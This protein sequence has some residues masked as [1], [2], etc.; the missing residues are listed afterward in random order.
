[1]QPSAEYSTY[2]IFLSRF[3]NMAWVYVLHNIFVQASAVKKVLLTVAEEAF[4]IEHFSL[5]VNIE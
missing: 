1:M 5:F 3:F 4:F 2:S